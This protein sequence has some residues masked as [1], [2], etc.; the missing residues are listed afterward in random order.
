MK[1]P[2]RLS[3]PYT[4][5]TIKRKAVLIRR[6]HS[7]Y[8]DLD[9][10]SEHAAYKSIFGIHE[11]FITG[12]AFPYFIEML[13]V[14]F[15]DPIHAER[16]VTYTG[17]VNYSIS[18]KEG[19]NMFSGNYDPYFY[20][21]NGEDDGE[22]SEDDEYEKIDDIRGVLASY[23]FHRYAVDTAKIPCVVILNLVTPKRDPHGH[24]KSSIDITPFAASI[25]QIVK[26]LAAD[27]KSYRSRGIHFRRPTERKSAIET[28]DNKKGA[29]ERMLIN[30]LQEN[31]GFPK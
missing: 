2:K 22:G 23:G 12:I 4:A 8:N 25:V 9:R 15:A 16:G 28:G 20:Y 14:P 31:R 11:D 3:V 24:D 10:N 27:I 1:P 6:L 29:L 5:N 30:Y 7:I 26:R 17:A 19:S 13:A 21:G 18:P